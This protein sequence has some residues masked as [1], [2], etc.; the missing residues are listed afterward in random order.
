MRAVVSGYS[1]IKSAALAIWASYLGLIWAESVSKSII[2]G[3]QTLAGGG[4]KFLSRTQSMIASILRFF[5]FPSSVAL[6]AIGWDKPYPLADR[7][8]RSM[9]HLSTRELTTLSARLWE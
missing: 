6:S 4:T 2:S 5:C 7:R 8:E 1:F 9:P 3:I